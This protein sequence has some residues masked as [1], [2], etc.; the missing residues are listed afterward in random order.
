MRL[1][2]NCSELERPKLRIHESHTL[3]IANASVVKAIDGHGCV[4]N[5][6]GTVMEKERTQASW[7]DGYGCLLFIWI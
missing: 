2:R 6:V 7:F 1:S 4:G 5:G 3:R